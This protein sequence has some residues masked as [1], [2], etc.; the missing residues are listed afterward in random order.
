[1][2][3]AAE[4]RFEAAVRSYWQVREHQAAKQVGS[5]K[6]DAGTG[7]QSQAAVT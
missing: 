5:G 6:V 2:R 1:M 3:S 4:A 7:E